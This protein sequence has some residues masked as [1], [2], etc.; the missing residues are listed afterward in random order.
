MELG[1]VEGIIP[2]VETGFEN[3]MGHS[4]N[5]LEDLLLAEYGKLSAMPAEELTEQRYKRFRK[6]GSY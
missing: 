2:E 6:F 1:I 5:Y 3:D 4:L